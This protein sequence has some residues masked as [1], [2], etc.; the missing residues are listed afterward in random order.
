M[1]PKSTDSECLQHC[2]ALLAE[3]V[4]LLSETLTPTDRA[5]GWTAA[6]KSTCED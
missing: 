2:A 4:Q 5:E 3:A 1:E 6:S